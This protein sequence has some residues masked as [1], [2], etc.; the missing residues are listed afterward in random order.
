[1]A[2]AEGS[3]GRNVPLFEIVWNGMIK[4]E[5]GGKCPSYSLKEVT[6]RLD[7]KTK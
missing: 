5:D 4:H 3:M 2:T 7:R 6:E 1:M